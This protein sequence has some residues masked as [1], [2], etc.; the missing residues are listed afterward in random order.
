MA[1]SFTENSANE[2]T[3]P[4]QHQLELSI[5]SDIEALNFASATP[6]PEHSI[7]DAHI[8][9]DFSPF[10][11]CSH[12]T[13]LMNSIKTIEKNIQEKLSLNAESATDF[14]ANFSWISTNFFFNQFQSH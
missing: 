4:S 10:M 2:C 9:N 3:G 8:F 5:V 14:N 13:Q 6:Y 7:T 1:D 12:V 11:R